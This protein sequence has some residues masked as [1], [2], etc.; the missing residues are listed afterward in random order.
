MIPSKRHG[1]CET[2]AEMPKKH[3]GASKISIGEPI[4]RNM[5]SAVAVLA[6]RPLELPLS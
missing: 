2:A 5:F 4:T 6:Y 1:F 3:Y